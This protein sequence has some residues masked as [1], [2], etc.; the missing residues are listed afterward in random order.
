MKKETTGTHYVPVHRTTDG[1]FNSLINYFLPE[2]CKVRSQSDFYYVT[3]IALASAGFIYPP[4]FIAFNQ[5]DNC[6]MAKSHVRFIDGL[7]STIIHGHP[8]IVNT[9]HE[10]LEML[11]KLLMI[12][13]DYE[14]FIVE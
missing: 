1:K 7:M 6:E 2:E 11:Q 3:A 10:R 13:Q 9:E 5:E 8:I 14:S 4:L 12:K